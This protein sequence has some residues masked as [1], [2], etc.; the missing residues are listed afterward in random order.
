MP[1]VSETCLLIVNADDL[2]R[3]AGVTEGI[4]QAHHQGI[5]TSTTTMVN[6]P[7]AEA[8][9]RRARCEAPRLGL[10]IHLNLTAGPSLLAPELVPTLVGGDG[11]FCSIRRVV[12]R[13]E[14]LD[15]G[16]VRAEMT[17]QIER[18]RSWRLEP[19]HLDCHH[20]ALYLSPR[21]FRVLV[22]LA[23]RYGLPIR[24]P[25][26]REV[27]S[28]G[29]AALLAEAHRVAVADLPGIMAGCHAILDA[30]GVP[31]PGRCILSFYGRRATLEHLLDLL[32]NVSPGVTELMCHP[33]IV[34]AG[35]RTTSGYAEGRERELAVLTDPQVRTALE[36][37]GV[38][39]VDYSA[40]A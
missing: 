22:E 32:A 15:V 3:S 6:L 21:L 27:R 29:E 16:E 19:T 12:R 20:H 36:A 11:W 23:E 10:G 1:A 33:G 17:A 4:L 28:P 38:G 39:L 26:P 2:G 31:A 25:W 7:D 8:S 13:L 30:S 18:F 14:D 9:V 34:D 37:A 35:L 40:L 24:Y 5:V